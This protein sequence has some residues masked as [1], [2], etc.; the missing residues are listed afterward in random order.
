MKPMQTLKQWHRIVAQRDTGLLD[1]V[2]A[3]D[4]VFHSPVVHTP[5]RGR[6]LTR[7]YLSGAMHVLRDNFRYVREVVGERDAVLE[8]L[9]DIDGIEVNGVDILQ[10][11]DEGR[12]CEFKVMLRP[13]KAINT[14]HERMRQMLESLKA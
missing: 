3:A 4:C 2:L 12:I 13:L 1:E 7:V 10:F 11:D 9:C 14:V 5:Q 8:F 6:E